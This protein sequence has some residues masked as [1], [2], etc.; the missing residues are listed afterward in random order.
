MSA[1]NFV[2]LKN[3]VNFFL[4]GRG[5]TVIK[6]AIKRLASIFVKATTASKFGEYDTVQLKR[7]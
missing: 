1:Q 5:K 4:L 6:N 3:S 7:V 2:T